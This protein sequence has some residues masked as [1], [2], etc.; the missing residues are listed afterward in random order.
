MLNF[1]GCLKLHLRLYWKFST[2]KK[3]ARVQISVRSLPVSPQF[4]LKNSLK[5]EVIN[6]NRVSF[7]VVL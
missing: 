6:L 4:V 3:M 7:S 1:F 5:L 2:N